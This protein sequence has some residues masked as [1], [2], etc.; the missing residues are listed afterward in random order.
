MKKADA[1]T[2][3]K[4]N[5]SLET[6]LTKARGERREAFAIAVEAVGAVGEAKKEN[7][8]I[9]EIVG[10]LRGALGRV[11]RL[12]AERERAGGAGNDGG[13]GAVAV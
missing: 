1:V 8:E 2:L 10:A 4:K 3:W 6:M 12:I 7:G 11:E 13:A 5:R 9:K